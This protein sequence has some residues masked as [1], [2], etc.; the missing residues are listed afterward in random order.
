MPSIA[1]NGL[2]FEYD[3]RGDPAHPVML[4][5]MGL[6][7]QMIFW[8]ESLC[9]MLAARGFRV[10]R[11]DNR[12]AGLTTKLDYLGMPKVALQAVKYALHLPVKASYCIEDM[13]Q[14]TS[15]LMT[16]L[17]IARAH[18]V[19]ASMGGMV[20]QNLAAH[21]SAQVATLTSIMSSTGSRRLPGPTS[22]ARKLL[23]SAPRGD[24][25]LE[26]A[27]V[28]LMKLL[29]V[30]GSRTHPAEEDELRVFCERHVR[31]SYYPPGAAR[32]LM[33][34]AASGDRTAVVRL[35][36]APSLVVH[37][38]EDPLMQLPCG[39]ATARAIHEGGGNVAM[40]VVRGM[41]HDFP[42]PLQEGLADRI[43]EHCR[44]NEASL[45]AT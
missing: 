32:Q 39:E 18:V 5:I 29:L 19:G 25:D 12:D 11:F 38:D 24:R 27:I 42:V 44:S 13:A 20:A 15:A 45:T 6:G 7:A 14:D 4:L 37:G 43:A 36:K 22:S 41:G 33:A 23:L 10:V 3:E 9:D 28:H 2:V 8:P 30:I 26:V 16:S 35:I 21:A 31:R 1:A 34:I 17:G 40:E